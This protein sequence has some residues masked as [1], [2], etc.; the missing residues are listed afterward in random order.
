MCDGIDDCDN[1]KDES[2]ETCGNPKPVAC[3]GFQGGS[4]KVFYIKDKLYIKYWDYLGLISIV[5]PNL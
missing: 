5:V 4:I 2:E 1:E 3:H